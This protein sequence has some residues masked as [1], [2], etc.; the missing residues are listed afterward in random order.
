MWCETLTSRRKLNLRSRAKWY[1]TGVQVVALDSQGR[2]N[3]VCTNSGDFGDTVPSA[4]LAC[5]AV[6]STGAQRHRNFPTILGVCCA[7]C[8]SSRPVYLAA[9]ACSTAGVRPAQVGWAQPSLVSNPRAR[10]RALPTT[11][12]TNTVANGDQQCSC[13][14]LIMFPVPVRE[15]RNSVTRRRRRRLRFNSRRARFPLLR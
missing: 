15:S 14:A 4:L 1:Q 6:C 11:T 12:K 2:Q 10:A 5:R 3:K 9:A 13:H 8:H 7:C